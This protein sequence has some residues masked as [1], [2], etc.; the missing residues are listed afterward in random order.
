[1]GPG[2]FWVTATNAA[3]SALN[4][5]NVYGS[6]AN[7]TTIRRD[8]TF[9][10]PAIDMGI[11]SAT[12]NCNVKDLTLDANAIGNESFVRGC[13][14]LFGQTNNVTRVVA[15]NHSG[16]WSTGKECFP[17]YLG[18][19]TNFDSSFNVIDSCVVSNHVG[20]Y[21]SGIGVNSRG[22]V[23]N[24]AAYF[25]N[26]VNTNMGV[27]GYQ[28]SFSVG[29]S[30]VGNFQSGGRNGFYNDSGNETN[31]TFT[32][33]VFSNVMCG[34]QIHKLTK[35]VDGL[36]LTS[37]TFYLSPLTSTPIFDGGG[38]SVGTSNALKDVVMS[39][40]FVYFISPTNT[41]VPAINLSCGLNICSMLFTNNTYDSNLTIK[42]VINGN[43]LTVSKT[44]GGDV[45]AYN[46]C[47]STHTTLTARPRPSYIFSAWSGAVSTVSPQIDYNTTSNSTLLASFNPVTPNRPGSPHIQGTH[48]KGGVAK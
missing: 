27:W 21:C 39:S 25:T 43:M 31:L 36:T 41:V 5:L 2:V 40:N 48:I 3:A 4:G 37:N 30:Y 7:Q 44:A 23:T 11:I 20:N 16:N 9:D 42:A 45:D 33:N 18:G 6:G 34:I 15:I 38:L 28:S 12:L 46:P 29:C 22:L 24:C 32:G 19:K 26:A 17:I 1:M 13:L 47:G 8:R 14:N 35:G 10:N